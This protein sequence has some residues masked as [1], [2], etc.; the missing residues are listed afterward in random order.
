[1]GSQTEPNAPKSREELRT[2]RLLFKKSEIAKLYKITENKKIHLIPLRIFDAHGL[3]KM[4][5]AECTKI[6]KINKKQKIKERDLD[7]SLFL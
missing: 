3:I 2:I 5:V 1:L 6:N 4:E 7:R